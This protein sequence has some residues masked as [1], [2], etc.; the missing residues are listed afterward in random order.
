MKN[1]ILIFALSGLALCLGSARTGLAAVPNLPSHVYVQGRQLMVQKRLADGTLDVARPYVIK[2]IVWQPATIAPATGPN[3]LD[4]TQTVQYGCFYDYAGRNPEGHVINNYWLE[5]QFA[6]YYT[7]DIPIIQQLNANTVRTFEPLAAD[8]QTSKQILDALYNAGIMVIMTVATSST[9]L[10]TNAYLTAVQQVQNH[11]AIL[12]WAVGNEWNMNLYYGGYATADSAIAATQQAAQDIHAIDP[13]HP[14]SSDLGD[15]FTPGSDTDIPT[16]VSSVTAVDLWGLNIYRGASFDNLFT[17][18][19]SATSKPFYMGEFGIDSFNTTAYSICSSPSPC[20]ASNEAIVT[21]GSEDQQTQSNWDLGLWKEIAGQLSATNSQAPCIGGNLF[22]FNN[23]LWE[24]GNYNVNLGGLPDPTGSCTNTTPNPGGFYISGASSDNVTNEEY[25]GIVNADRTPKI[26]YTTMQSYY[27]ALYPLSI[28]TVSSLNPN[29]GLASVSS[30]TLTITGSNF[31]SNSFIFWNGA[32]IPA[33]YLNSSELQ[34]TISASDITQAS[35]VNL[36]VV[37]P[38]AT[39]GTSALIPYPVQQISGLSAGRVSPDPW[40][41]DRN[42]GVPITFDQLT[43][44]SQIKIFTLSG[45]WVRTLDASDGFA[46]WDLRNDSGENVAS[47]LYLYVLTN[48]QGQKATGKL[49]IIR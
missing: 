22:H 47:G 14:V 19:T 10:S 48:S 20:P 2:G 8:A 28:P 17:Q 32:V 27:Q 4:P 6:A 49:A 18:M 30:F 35:T 25:F 29:V 11:P 23:E 45:H 21:Q 24:V 9:D 3:P 31:E 39:G 7:Q 41:S 13:N 26:A 12:M 34:V 37:N 5:S 16:I 33:T 42:G 36:F 15:I 1:K 43:L 46:N 40:R 38:S 44:G